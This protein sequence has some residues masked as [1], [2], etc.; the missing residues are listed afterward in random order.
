LVDDGNGGYQIK[1]ILRQSVPAAIG[2]PNAANEVNDQDD[3]VLYES[4]NNEFTRTES[5]WR[6]RR[7]GMSLTNAKECN[8]IVRQFMEID[9]DESMILT[10]MSGETEFSRAVSVNAEL[11]DVD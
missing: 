11:L 5:L 4:A 8:D 9:F 1:F 3:N 6:D 10:D 2:V 7:R